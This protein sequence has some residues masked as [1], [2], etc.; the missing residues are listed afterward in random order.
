M[1]YQVNNCRG[2]ISRG[3]E[4]FPKTINSRRAEWEYRKIAKILKLI[5]HKGKLKKESW[6]NWVSNVVFSRR[7]KFLF[8]ILMKDN[9]GIWK[10]AKN[11]KKERFQLM[12]TNGNI[13]ENCN[14]LPPTIGVLRL[15][16]RTRIRALDFSNAHYI[17]TTKV[18][19]KNIMLTFIGY[20]F[21][22][23]ALISLNKS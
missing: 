19:K 8:R 10:I 6:I 12:T 23:F 11:L 9:F 13:F 2:L 1:Y 4:I 7:E 18:F 14:W 15:H 20:C 22:W 5:F 16:K 21:V 3:A 17:Q